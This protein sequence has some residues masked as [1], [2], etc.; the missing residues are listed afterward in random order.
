MAECQTTNHTI[1]IDSSKERTP[2]GNAK[3]GTQLGNVVIN[4]PGEFILTLYNGDEPVAVFNRPKTSGTFTYNCLLD[5]GLAFTLEQA[6]NPSGTMYSITV[7]Y[8]EGP[9]QQ[10]AQ[11]AI[12]DLER[13]LELQR[14]R[15]VSP[16]F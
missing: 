9:R 4:T 15:Q 8:Y 13:R 5:K 1:S 16:D 6:P 12:S 7:A 3:G 2:I 10:T 14:Q 11:E